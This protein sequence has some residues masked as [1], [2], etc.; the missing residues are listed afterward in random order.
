LNLQ[1]EAHYSLPAHKRQAPTTS[2]EM[3]GLVEPGDFQSYFNL[4]ET[5]SSKAQNPMLITCGSM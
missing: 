3:R 5:S 4:G 1:T 2:N